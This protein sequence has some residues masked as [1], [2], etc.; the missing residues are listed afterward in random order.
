ME[1]AYKFRIYPNKEQALL[2]QKTF[3]SVRFVYNHYLAKR[4]ELYEEQGVTFGYNKCSSDMTQLKKQDEY[5]WLKEVDSTALQSSLKDL[6]FAFKNFFRRVKQ[7]DKK[8]GYPRFKS[9][10]FSKKSYT[11]KMNIRLEE[12]HIVLPKLGLVKCRVSRQIEGRILSATIEQRPS[13]KYFVSVLCTEVEV[14]A[15]DKTGLNIGVDLGLKTLVTLS[16]GESYSHPKALNKSLKKLAKLQK[17]LSRKQIGSSNRNKA[18]IKVARLHE[19][20]SNQRNDFSHKLSTNMVH[21]FDVIAIEHL[22][23]KNMV[24][25]KKL[26]RHITDASWS[27]FVRQMEYKADWYGKAVVKVDTFFPSSQLCSSC[28]YQNSEVKDLKI[29]KWTCPNCNAT[30]DRDLNASLN[31]RNIGINTVGHTEIYACGEFVRPA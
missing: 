9:K 2:M 26:A 29:R 11:A 10:K 7:G 24:K 30:H 20:I 8:V 15:F 18:R 14:E 22:Q 25:N 4:I 16:N 28:G 17:Q 5:D 13:G 6:D 1:K 3:G 31:I 12:R 19:K 27:E 21:G 23:V